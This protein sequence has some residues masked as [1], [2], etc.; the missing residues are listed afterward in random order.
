MSLPLRSPQ[1]RR[2]APSA[3]LTLIRAAMVSV[4]LVASFAGCRTYTPDPLDLAAHRVDL[5]DRLAHP[6]PIDALARRLA[7]TDDDD[8]AGVS[9][10]RFDPSDGLSLAEAEVLALFANPELRVQRAAAKVARADAAIAGQWSD[11]VFGFDA[12]EI[13]S[14]G[15]ESGAVL[16]L[17]LPIS[18]AAAAERGVA[19]A[20]TWVAR[21]KLA[22]A[23]WSIRADVRRAWATW[24]AATERAHV[25]RGIVE[26]VD[27]VAEI[28]AALEA[29][30]Q[31]ARVESRLLRLE[32]AGR[33]AELLGLEGDATDARL[34]LLALVGLP[35]DADVSLIPSLRPPNGRIQPEASD[36]DA[37]SD[38]LIRH[39]PGLAIR[40]AEHAVAEQ[41]VR[42]AVRQ[43]YPDITIGGGLGRE[44]GEDRL[45]LG[46]SLPI[47][48]PGPANARID[49]AEARRTASHRMAEAT[50]DHAM[51]ALVAAMARQSAARTQR[52]RFES[53][54]APM[55]AEQA[56]DIDRIAALGE[57]DTLLL[58]EAVTSRYE[59]SRQLVD[60]REAELRAAATVAELRGPDAPLA[61]APV[62][63]PPP[64]SPPTDND[65]PTS[66]GPSVSAD[67]AADSAAAFASVSAPR[68]SAPEG[69]T[70]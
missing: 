23:E 28:A 51:S 18:G 43:Q 60:V 69:P 59:A 29:A 40:R 32:Q 25:L 10:A 53:R 9:P 5:I 2:F 48:L 66:G 17:T 36:A 37:L 26:Q 39:H 47:P 22:A 31:L 67:S 21:L 68:R 57:L 45:L 16:E 50:Y 8:P 62:V 46:V 3:I 42:L 34:A 44:D 1:R 12:A 14:G 11:P 63:E 19:D 56:A 35:P 4:P 6:E 61:P 55:L 65:P 49:A 58:F 33:Q 7:G 70:S 38:R 24:S 64:E 20:E 13:L 15:F 54:I 30:G 27:R 41:A 52:E